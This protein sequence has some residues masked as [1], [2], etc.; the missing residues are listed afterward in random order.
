MLTIYFTIAFFFWQQHFD[1]IGDLKLYTFPAG[2]L[3]CVT[4]G[5]LLLQFSTPFEIGA[6][7]ERLP[8]SIQPQSATRQPF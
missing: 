8:S 7:C 1:K 5:W 2:S 3:V 6:P 4:F